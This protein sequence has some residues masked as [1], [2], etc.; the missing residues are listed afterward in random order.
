MKMLLAISILI[1]TASFAGTAQCEFI[2]E[3]GRESLDHDLI[4]YRLKVSGLSGKIKWRIPLSKTFNGRNDVALSR[5]GYVDAKGSDSFL[6]DLNVTDI[7]KLGDKKDISVQLEK[8]DA[9]VA[10]CKTLAAPSWSIAKA[11]TNN[12]LIMAGSLGKE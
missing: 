1:N 7:A 5:I 11:A 12:P 9:T 8:G 6:I 3:G 10:S 4:W 2:P